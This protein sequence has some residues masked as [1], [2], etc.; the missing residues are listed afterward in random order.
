[1][2]CPVLL[3]NNRRCAAG[4]ASLARQILT[5][6][7]STIPPAPLAPRILSRTGQQRQAPS[8]RLM[9]A[10]A[11]GAIGPL[12]KQCSLCKQKTRRLQMN[13]LEL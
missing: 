7:L 4:D 3:T 6:S 5:S 12:V 11:A 10:D 2:E 1:M 8:C 13:R 9:R